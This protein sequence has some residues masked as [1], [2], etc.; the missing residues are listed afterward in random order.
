MGAFQKH[1]NNNTIIKISLYIIPSFVSFRLILIFF[2]RSSTDA[3]GLRPFLS[4]NLG[5]RQAEPYKLRDDQCIPV[6]SN[7]VAYEKNNHG[8]PSFFS[9]ERYH[10]E[11]QDVGGWTILTGSQRDRMG[12]CE[13]D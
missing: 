13:L 11:D 6:Q 3:L 9:K 4:R 2:S 8:F 1:K 5:M 7:S 10:W 12:W